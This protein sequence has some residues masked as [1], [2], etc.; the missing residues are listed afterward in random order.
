MF[1]G[2]E[3]L[4]DAENCDA[5]KLRDLANVRGIFDR[6]VDDLGLKTVG[7]PTWHKFPEAGGVTGLVMLTESHFACHTYPEHGIATFNLYCC[8]T[9]P[10]WNWEA[11]LKEIL[12]AT[13]VNVQKV[14]RGSSSSVEISDERSRTGNG[15]SSNHKKLVHFGEINIRERGRLPHWEKEEGVYFVT[16]RLADSLPKAILSQIEA[17]RDEAL[18]ALEN[19]DRELSIAEKHKIEWMFSDKVDD[20]LDQGLGECHLRNSEIAEIV[21]GALKHFDNQRYHLFSW[22]VMP[23]HVHVVFRAIQKNKLEDILHSWKSFTAKEANK[24]LDKTGQFWQREYYDH[25]VRD[26][27]ELNR[28]IQY[29]LDNPK[30]AGFKDW[31]WVWAYGKY[32]DS[33]ANA[34]ISGKL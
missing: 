10:E 25:L 13:T 3:W 33:I 29:V 14:V 22:C 31:K 12:G 8:R 20:Y 26:Q 27:E 21:A 4:I 30:K 19:L 34:A 15:Q 9:R 6:V 7:E 18:K 23:N 17:E 24:I 1:V 16:V 11:N 2:T 32:N 5:E 28:I